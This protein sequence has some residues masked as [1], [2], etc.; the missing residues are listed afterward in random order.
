[1]RRRYRSNRY[2]PYDDDRHY[3]H[4]RRRRRFPFLKVTLCLLGLGALFLIGVILYTALAPYFP[5][6]GKVLLGVLG[7]VVVAGVLWAILFLYGMLQEQLR[8][9]AERQ[10]VRVQKN[11]RVVIRD[12]RTRN[13]VYLDDQPP[14]QAE[15]PLGPPRMVQQQLAQQANLPNYPPAGIPTPRPTTVPFRSYG[16]QSPAGSPPPRPTQP[17]AGSPPVPP[18]HPSGEPQQR[19]ISFAHIRGSIRPGQVLKGIRPDDRVLRLGDWEDF[20]TLLVLGS[21]ASGKTNTIAEKIT[22][23]TQ[24]GMLLAVCDPHAHKPDSLYRRIAPL[25][26][27]LYPGCTLATTH[28]DILRNFRFV[29]G[30]LERRIRGGKHSHKLLI[31]CDEWNRLQ[32]DEA[33]AR[34]L[35]AIAEILGEEGRDFGVYGIFGTQHVTYNDLKKYVVSVIVHRCA[36]NEAKLVIPQRYAKLAPELS[37]GLTY[38]KDADGMTELLQQPYI[39]SRDI[40]VTASAMPTRSYQAPATE[41]PQRTTRQFSSPNGLT[42]QTALEPHGTTQNHL[43]RASNQ[44]LVRLLDEPQT[45][46]EPPQYTVGTRQT[47]P[48]NLR[49][50]IIRLAKAGKSRRQIREELG[51]RGAK[52]EIVRQVL[53]S[54]GL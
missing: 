3:H 31:A 23:A 30:E 27:F 5:I 29:R 43:N 15:P 51:L 26:G 28:E 10:L 53:D 25:A 42:K 18:L 41:Q 13:L 17:L 40:E 9:K 50:D 4:Y 36:E 34:E 33:I 49:A 46:D 20:K 48:Q 8:K 38:V 39:T 12:R 11:E 24:G 22:E 37:N 21:M 2:D 47:I 19:I 35:L 54:A 32:R 45:T 52:Y 6:I 16:Y 14:A 1:M 7:F 44:R